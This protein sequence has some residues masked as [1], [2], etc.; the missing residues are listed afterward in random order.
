MDFD[1][2]L[3]EIKP[4]KIEKQKVESLADSM[5]D[6]INNLA[7][8]KGI[9]TEAILVGSVAK[10]TWLSGNADIDIFLHFPLETPLAD[11]KEQ[12]LYLGHEC[13]IFMFGKSEERYA[14]HPYV[15]GYINGYS[16][17]FVPCYL[18]EDA[19]QLK[20]AVDRTILHTHY[21]KEN[22]KEN[23][24]DDV[25]ILKKFMEGIETYGSEFKVGGFAGYLCE[26]L[27][28]EYGT[29]NKVLKAAASQWKKGLII[30]LENFG[31]GGI[32][33]DSLIVVDPT[34]KKRN[35]AAALTTQKMAEFM[36]AA[37]N[38]L[39]CS[40]K[41]TTNNTT[42]NLEYF[43]SVTYC[44]D[45]DSIKEEFA[46]NGT[47]TFLIHFNPPEIPSDAIYPQ[48]KKT[49]MSLSSKLELEGFKV[50]KSSY[51]TN[52]YNIALIMLEFEVWELP[53]YKIHEGPMVWDELHQERFL[54]KYSYGAWVE[55]DRWKVQVPQ[56]NNNAEKM[57]EFFLKPENIHH[58]KIGK[59]LKDEILKNNVITDINEFLSSEN[60]SK[61]LLEFM[62]DFLNPGKNLWR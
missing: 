38:F 32:F 10:N 24:I 57:I 33:A 31:T 34:D 30:D 25:L 35:V 55:N 22:L 36:V 19:E 27:I 42:N 20:S 1:A 60:V 18:I 37:R 2:L 40:T 58:L 4:N 12:G 21:I 15:T 5:I 50:F 23:Q 44:N 62:D 16:V 53:N 46:D 13:I 52:E 49:E 7:Q 43:Q 41:D 11:L 26:L 59:H 51:W 6:F 48:L 47:K 17:D 56:K 3:N 29:F 45:L 9:Q 39:K 14:S 54:D 28:L 61:E 8:K